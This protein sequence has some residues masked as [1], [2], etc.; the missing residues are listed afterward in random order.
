MRRDSDRPKPP[1]AGRR[2][3]VTRPKEQAGDLADRLAALGAQPILCPT[4]R[5]VP[6]A[7]FG[8]LD[9]AL[10]HL[11]AYD[12]VIF[13]SV[14]GVS[15]FTERMAAMALDLGVLRHR[16]LRLAA[17]GPATAAALAAH[18]LIV[19]FMPGEYVAE[20]ILAGIGDVSGQR[21]LLPRA[22][23]ARKALAD[24][25]RGM[26]ALVDEAS[27]SSPLPARRPFVTSCSC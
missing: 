3:L 4:V 17:I 27:T 5:I 24:G 15:F 23:I 16:Q 8:P 1:L 22:D 14:N 25:L 6:P 2:V 13:T 12:W 20:A 21:I 19:S 7:D 10:K 11:D 9:D 18:G 26:G